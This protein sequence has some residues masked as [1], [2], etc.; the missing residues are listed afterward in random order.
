M[1]VAMRAVMQHSP[2]MQGAALDEP[3]RH[4]FPAIARDVAIFDL[5]IV[6]TITG[7]EI[8]C[9]KE[10]EIVIMRDPVDEARS[11]AGPQ[12]LIAFT[13]PDIRPE[14]AAT[15]DR[16]K[17][18]RLRS[19]TAS[20]KFGPMGIA[21]LV[22]QQVSEEGP[23]VGQPREMHCGGFD[24]FFHAGIEARGDRIDS[25]LERGSAS[26]RRRD[27]PWHQPGS[28]SRDGRSRCN[29]ASSTRAA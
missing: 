14:K 18:D 28:E 4:G 19:V 20:T 3:Q 9:G 12:A 7:S 21:Q 2:A 16:R 29:C 13:R 1:D 15:D 26:D 5:V 10:I 8:T 11:A 17:H 23:V 24:A 25:L 6:A 22:Q 27:L